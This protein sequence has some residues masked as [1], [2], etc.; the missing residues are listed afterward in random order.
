MPVNHPA[1]IEAAEQPLIRIVKGIVECHG[2]LDRY[3]NAVID[4]SADRIEARLFVTAKSVLS[5]QVQDERNTADWSAPAMGATGLF[6]GLS[7]SQP[8]AAF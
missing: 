8:E 6:A 3:G 1:A 2:I 4:Q 7:D 5:V